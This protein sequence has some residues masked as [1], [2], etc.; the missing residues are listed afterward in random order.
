MNF[1]ISTFAEREVFLQ[2]PIG[3]NPSDQAISAMCKLFDSDRVFCAGAYLLIRIQR[4]D[5]LLALVA[6][7][8]RVPFHRNSTAA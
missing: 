8:K 6:R 4:C 1:A 5:E 3:P 2:L 7:P